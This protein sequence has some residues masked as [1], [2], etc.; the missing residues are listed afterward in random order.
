MFESSL[1]SH[2]RLIVHSHHRLI[3]HSHHRLSLHSHHRL[4]V[5]S[6]HNLL[7]HSHHRL[8]LHTQPPHAQVYT[9]KHKLHDSRPKKI[10]PSQA[11]V[12]THTKKKASSWRALEK[13]KAITDKNIHKKKEYNFPEKGIVEKTQPLTQKLLLFFRH[14]KSIFF[15]TYMCL[16]RH[17]F[18]LFC[19][20]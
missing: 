16:E 19:S 6:H 2:H 8:L 13:T 7:F 17:K 9:K 3:V 11:K 18:S 12:H 15:C 4:S 10:K 14:I 5:H 20:F 1:E